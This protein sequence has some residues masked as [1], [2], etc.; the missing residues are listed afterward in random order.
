MKKIWK[1]YGIFV[2]P[3]K[4]LTTPRKSTRKKN[5]AFPFF[6]SF[7]LFFLQYTVKKIPH[8]TT[9]KSGEMEVPTY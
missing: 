9:L 5:E 4:E 8:L 3:G 1:K 2:H 6:F 7:F